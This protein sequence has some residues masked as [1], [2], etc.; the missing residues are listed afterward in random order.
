MQLV[1]HNDKDRDC[2]HSND[3]DNYYDN[4][5]RSNTGTVKKEATFT[6]PI[7]TNKQHQL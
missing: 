2:D 3:C 4:Y 7:S 1:A 6:T 5:N